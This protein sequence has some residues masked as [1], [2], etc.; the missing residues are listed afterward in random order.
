MPREPDQILAPMPEPAGKLAPRIAIVIDD[1][2]PNPVAA[3][4]AVALDARVTLAVLPYVGRARAIAERA[5]A[6][7]HEVLLHMPME[8]IG[9]DADPGPNALLATLD[10]QEMIRR[11][12]WALDQVPGA[13]GVNNHMGSRLTADRAAMTQVLGELKSRGLFF[14]DSRT[15]P[16]S[17]AGDLADVL[18][19]PHGAR[20]IFLDNEVS[21]EGVVSG[22]VA[23]EHRAREHG[24]AIAIGHP[25]AVTMATIQAWLPAAHR[26]GFEIVPVS[27]LMR[28]GEV[29]P[30]LTGSPA[31]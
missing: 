4:L 3:E 14:L 6:H 9:S 28:R 13:A 5:R 7:G 17:V 15:G 19:L 8:P 11:L 30:L 21:A 10:D 24:T 12:R 20:D 2:G 16:D 18:A 31:R 29:E 26:R 22:L 23:A 27:A 25:H 1:I